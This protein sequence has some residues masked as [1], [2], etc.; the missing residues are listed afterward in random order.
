[1]AATH[2]V[3]RRVCLSGGD[4]YCKC[5]DCIHSHRING[6]DYGKPDGWDDFRKECD[7]E[8]RH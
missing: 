7:C 5:R 2:I 4:E 1:M 8:Y 3:K 6:C